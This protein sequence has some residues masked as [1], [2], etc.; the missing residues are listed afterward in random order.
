MGSAVRLSQCHSAMLTCLH[1]L[2]LVSQKRDLFS[3]LLPLPGMALAVRLPEVGDGEPG[4][5]PERLH[6]LVPEQFLDVVHVG[7]RTQQP[8]GAGPAIMPSSA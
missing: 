6:V 4:V 7:A 8:G 5:V 2:C 1:V 3:I